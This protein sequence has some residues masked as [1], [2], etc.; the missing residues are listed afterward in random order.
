MKNILFQDLRQKINGKNVFDQSVNNSTKKS[1]TLQKLN[2][3]GGLLHSRVFLTL[4]TLK[5]KRPT[6]KFKEI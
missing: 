6:D 4:F 2:R 3:I 1:E 5:Q